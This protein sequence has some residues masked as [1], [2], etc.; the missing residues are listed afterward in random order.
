MR[1]LE[2]VAT[3]HY[4]KGTTATGRL[5]SRVLR[6]LE[7]IA[8]SSSEDSIEAQAILSDALDAGLQSRIRKVLKQMRVEVPLKS[9]KSIA[10]PAVWGVQVKNADGRA[11]FQQLLWMQMDYETF[12]KLWERERDR[13]DLQRG[14][15][16]G[17][18]AVKRIYDQHRDA[19]TAGDACRE[20]GFDPQSLIVYAEGRA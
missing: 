18:D 1:L 5:A 13:S 19:P 7:R 12:S 15:F 9:G 6:D 14:V 8:A 4:D 2:R 20:E 3:K 10:I 11:E 17:L 16:S